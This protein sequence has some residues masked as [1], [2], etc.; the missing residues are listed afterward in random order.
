MCGVTA[1]GGGKVQAWLSPDSGQVISPLGFSFSI[2]E[3]KVWAVMGLQRSFEISYSAVCILQSGHVWPL[4]ERSATFLVGTE[5]EDTHAMKGLSIGFSHEKC[6][7]T[8]LCL[9]THS[10][11]LTRSPGFGTGTPP[12]PA[13]VP[14]PSKH[15]CSPSTDSWQPGTKCPK[16]CLPV[17]A[18]CPLSRCHRRELAGLSAVSKP[19]ELLELQNGEDM[20][21]ETGEAASRP[22][23]SWAAME[24]KPSQSDHIIYWFSW[25][26][27]YG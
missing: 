4:N 8:P 13:P 10:H 11:G 5:A 18:H 26:D 25:G 14:L 9:I 16:A 3:L 1:L 17:N 7:S 20:E 23:G 21:I 27:L 22:E 19:K 6:S 15:P 2:C 12:H 24:R